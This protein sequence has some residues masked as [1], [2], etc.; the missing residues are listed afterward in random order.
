[1]SKKEYSRYRLLFSS[2]ERSHCGKANLAERPHWIA[3]ISAL[4]RNRIVLRLG[5]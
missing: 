4:G 3:A 1:M 5:P 2:S